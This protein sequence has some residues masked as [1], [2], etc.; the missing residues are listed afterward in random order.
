MGTLVSAIV[1][2]IWVILGLA[3]LAYG[4]YIT[5]YPLIRTI[6]GGVLVYGERRRPTTQ[7]A[8]AGMA[9]AGPVLGLTLADGGDE[10]VSS[11]EEEGT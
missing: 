7:H 4:L 6:G 8:D 9:T 1:F 10:V 5:F 11:D 2:S 3:V